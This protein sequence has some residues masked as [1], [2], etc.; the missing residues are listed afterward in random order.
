MKFVAGRG[1]R[2]NPS[3]RY[4]LGEERNRK[5][6][7]ALCRGREGG[8][9]N[10]VVGFRY[11]VGADKVEVFKVVAFGQYCEHSFGHFLNSASDPRM[12]PIAQ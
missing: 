9:S 8:F 6:T 1:A 2:Q 11:R 3:S 4:L 5:G 7:R 10:D 12:V